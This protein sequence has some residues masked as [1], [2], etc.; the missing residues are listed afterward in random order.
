MI[1]RILKLPIPLKQANSQSQLIQR[2]DNDLLG[3]TLCITVV[4]QNKKKL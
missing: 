4:I 1:I 3:V 2:E